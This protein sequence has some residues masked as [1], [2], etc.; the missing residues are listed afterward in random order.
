MFYGPSVDV[1]KIIN[2]KDK[3]EAVTEK[4]DFATEKAKRW[5]ALVRIPEEALSEEENKELSDLASYLD[6]ELIKN[7]PWLKEIPRKWLARL[8]G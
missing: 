5:Y 8:F 7:S 2:K 4:E 1:L 3:G 6:N